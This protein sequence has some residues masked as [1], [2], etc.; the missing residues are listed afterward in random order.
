[1]KYVDEYRHTATVN[2]LVEAIHATCRRNWT[3][4]EICGGQTHNI[5][6][7]GLDQMLPSGVSIVHGPGCPVCVTPAAVMDQAIAIAGRP[8]VTLCTF[9]DMLRV[10]GSTG[11]LA[12]AK[13]EG[14]DVR[15]V[16]SPLDALALARR[17]PTRQVVFLAIGFE[18]TA[19]A[20]AVAVDQARQQD[21]RNFSLLCSL[22]RVPPAMAAILSAAENRVQ[23]FLAAG[24]VCTVQ[25][26]GEYAAISRRFSV[27]IVVTGFEPVDLL[28]GLLACIRQLEGGHA[29]VENCYGRWVRPDGNRQAQRLVQTVFE[30]C[31]CE[32]RGMGFMPAGGLSLRPSYKAFDAAERFSAHKPRK[33]AVSPCISGMIMQGRARPEDCPAFGVGCTPAHP[34]GAPMV[35]SEGACAAYFRF[36]RPMPAAS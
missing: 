33:Q 35:S 9:G 30:V 20:Y 19:P 1:M 22:V 21:L 12:R 10:P 6:R 24:H 11:D 16:Y 3:I 7:F 2:R 34:L 13:A 14:A 15:I 36:R 4:M 23:G 32:W 31:D 26:L 29:E 25:G 5:L 17:H 27:P 8:Q 18:T 28:M